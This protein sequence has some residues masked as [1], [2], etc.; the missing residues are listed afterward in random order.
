MQDGSGQDGPGAARWL[1]IA[2]VAS[3][4]LSIVGFFVLGG[5]APDE[6][7]TGDE[8]VAYYKAHE[9]KHMLAAVLVALA[10][11]LF[12]FLA[13]WLRN[14]LRGAGPTLAGAAFG[15]GIVFSGALLLQVADHF[16]LVEAAH[17][18]QADIAH[19]LNLVDNNNFLPFVG[20]IAVLLLAV[21]IATLVHPALPRWFGWVSVVIGVAAMAGP[22]GV[23]AFF[24]APLWTIGVSVLL[25]RLATT[26]SPALAADSA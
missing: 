8:V 11:V 6:K 17:N 2:G 9:G 12:V 7:S 1:M 25:Y 3:G 21:G 24:L 23:I 13:S 15:G 22:L 18:G 4:V 26:A 16:E 14:A 5:G 20:G 19:T 10:A